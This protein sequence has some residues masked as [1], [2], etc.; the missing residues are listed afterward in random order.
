MNSKKSLLLLGVLI[1]PLAAC[2]HTGSSYTG[3]YTASSPSVLVQPTHRAWL[4]PGSTME[5]ENVA[6]KECGDELRGNEQLRKGSR[7]AWSAAFEACMQR[8]GFRYYKD[9]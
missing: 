6:R 4:K 2:L 3:P 9:R 7:S 5:D 8:K 1:L